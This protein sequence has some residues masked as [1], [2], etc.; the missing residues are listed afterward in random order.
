MIRAILFDLDGVV[1]DSEPLYQ[2]GE[3]R[4]F[5]EYDIEI[6]EEDWKIFRG[7]TEKKFYQMARDRYGLIEE[8]ETLRK[9]GRQYVLEEF[10]KDLEYMPGFAELTQR[11]GALY[12][13]G[14][15]TASPEDMFNWINSRLNLKR[16][17]DDF[18]FGG[19]TVNGKPHP[20]PYLTMMERLDVSAEEC[21]VIEDSL[22][23]IHSGLSS[24]AYVIALTGSVP[25][26][27]LAPAHRIVEHLD[28]ITAELINSF[29]A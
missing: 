26:P 19:M 8:A 22:H 20:E 16:Y 1:I 21:I 9:K 27:D 6:P 25:V 17:F 14:L 24:G 2:R 15:V 11:L 18:V 10:E 5:R 3:V 7:S 12:K 29:Q 23:G 13:R 28:E 4:L